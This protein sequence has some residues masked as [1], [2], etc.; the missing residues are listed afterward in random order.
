A[1]ETQA[2]ELVTDELEG[3]ED[4]RHLQQALA[5]LPAMYRRVLVAH[6][7]EGQSIRDIARRERVPSGTVL[8]RIHNGKQR[9]REAWDTSVWQP[10][11]ELSAPAERNAPPKLETAAPAHLKTQRTN[12]P[13]HM[14]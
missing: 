8:S 13:K 3:R 1:R 14:D 11:R 5:Q 10:S 9:L 6:F 2:P 4:R 12:T 7:V